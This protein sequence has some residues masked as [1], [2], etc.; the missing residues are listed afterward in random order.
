M[1]FRSSFVLYFNMVE[2]MNK[3]NRSS[4]G[5]MKKMSLGCCALLYFNFFLKYLTYFESRYDNLL[6]ISQYSLDFIVENVA[7]IS[8]MP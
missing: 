1:N 5:W 4:N 2:H 7:L 3:L 8:C 6:Y